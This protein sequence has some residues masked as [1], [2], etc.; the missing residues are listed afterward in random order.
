MQA[1]PSFC[2]HIE[3]PE[4]ALDLHLDDGFPQSSRRDGRG[5]SVLGEEDGELSWVQGEVSSCNILGGL[6]SCGV[7][8]GHV[9]ELIISAYRQ[10]GGRSPTILF[11]IREG[12]LY[13]YHAPMRLEA[14]LLACLRRSLLNVDVEV[15]AK[16]FRNASWQGI[17]VSRA[18]KFCYC[19]KKRIQTK[20]AVKSLNVIKNHVVLLRLCFALQS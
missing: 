16:D 19:R 20:I 4:S 15:V 12:N 6:R 10:R 2:L 7:V 1:Q 5:M 13:V 18:Q 17:E 8:Q 14:S 11:T 3:N 9:A